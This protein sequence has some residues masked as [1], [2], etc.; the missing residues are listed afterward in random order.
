TGYE[1]RKLGYKGL[2][3]GKTGTTSDFKDGWFMG[4][5]PEYL[6]LVWV[7]YDQGDP[8]QWDG[9]HTALPIWVA[10]MDK[11][12]GIWKPET[13][14]EP[15]KDLTLVADVVSRGVD[16]IVPEEYPSD[17]NSKNGSIDPGA[18]DSA[19]SRREITEALEYKEYSIEN[20]NLTS[21]KEN[22]PFSPYPIL[23]KQAQK[24]FTP[25]FYTKDRKKRAPQARKQERKTTYFPP[26]SAKWPW[27]K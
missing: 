9:T 14:P 22:A 2:V 16:C 17:C 18:N 10:F 6:T 21:I 15:S 3:A 1:A 8:I 12:Y 13:S 4:Y 23:N 7:G 19:P 11:I 26:E 24:D 20:K 5:T 25:P 27:L